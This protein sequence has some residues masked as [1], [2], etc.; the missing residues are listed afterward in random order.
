MHG[1]LNVNFKTVAPLLR[2]GLHFHNS[3]KDNLLP[4]FNKM[5]ELEHLIV[6]VQHRTDEL[7]C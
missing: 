3:F 5:A 7:C 6:G 4:N 1:P 2:L